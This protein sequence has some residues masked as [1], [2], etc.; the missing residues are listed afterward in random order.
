MILL[1]VAWASSGDETIY[2][3]GSTGILK[4]TGCTPVTATGWLPPQRPV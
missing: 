4:L 3:T 2:F 1:R